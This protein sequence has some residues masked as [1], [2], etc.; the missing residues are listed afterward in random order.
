MPGARERL[1]QPV[2][3]GSACEAVCMRRCCY[4]LDALH[5][6]PD[7]VWSRK[8]VGVGDSGMGVTTDLLGTLAQDL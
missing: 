1:V 8:G 4:K 2:I 5:L 3:W 6:I 7:P